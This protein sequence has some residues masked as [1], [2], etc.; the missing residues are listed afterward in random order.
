MPARRS[1]ARF[2][3]LKPPL[4]AGRTGTGLYYGVK[5]NPYCISRPQDR[6]ARRLPRTG[7]DRALD[8]V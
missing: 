1:I 6:A 3:P 8:F 4:L 2:Y 5:V 7:F